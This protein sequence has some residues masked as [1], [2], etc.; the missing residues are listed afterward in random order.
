MKKNKDIDPIYPLIIAYLTTI[1]IT[2]AW[3]VYTTK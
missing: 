3:E 1:A 2:L